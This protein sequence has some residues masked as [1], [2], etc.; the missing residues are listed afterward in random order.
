[1]LKYYYASTYGRPSSS[2]TLLISVPSWQWQNSRAVVRRAAP[3]IQPGKWIQTKNPLPE[4]FNLFDETLHT[5]KVRP[6][7]HR[8]ISPFPIFSLSRAW[9]PSPE[10]LP[11][12]LLS[13]IF[14][15]FV[16]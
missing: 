11:S 4:D 8:D 13:R 9:V 10:N 2:N 6:A 3:Q 14:C 7:L 12:A 15:S 16:K 5:L 1:M